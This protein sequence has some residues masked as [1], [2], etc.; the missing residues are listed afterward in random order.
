MT[1]PNFVDAILLRSSI[2]LRRYLLQTDN[3]LIKVGPSS[4]IAFSTCLPTHE[5]LA[6]CSRTL[7]YTGFTERKDITW[8]RN[9][10]ELSVKHASSDVA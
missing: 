4:R 3:C 6:P 2:F 9:R 1:D 5:V 8:L 10:R 7:H